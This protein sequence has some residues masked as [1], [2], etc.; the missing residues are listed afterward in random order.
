MSATVSSRVLKIARDASHVVFILRFDGTRDKT[1][2][3]LPNVPYQRPHSED[4]ERIGWL[5]FAATYGGDE[6]DAATGSGNSA[7]SVRSRPKIQV[8]EPGIGRFQRSGLKIEN[9]DQEKARAA[10]GSEL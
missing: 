7:A 4:A 1:L 5:P 2:R 6:T 3:I 8:P 10:N 9:G